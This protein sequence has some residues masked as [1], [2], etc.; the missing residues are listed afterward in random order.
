MTKCKGCGIEIQ[1]SDPK[2]LGY[3]P[4]ADSLYCQRCFRLMHYD[5]LQ[6]S[7]KQGID[8][9]VV[10]AGIAKQEGLI[11]WVCDIF[12]FEA[13]MIEGLNRHL[14]GRDILMVITKRDL[15]PDTLS[16][17]K[18]KR[19]ILER[20]KAYQIN[21]KGIIVTGKGI[22]NK[23]DIFAALELLAYHNI[24]V[25]GKANVGK[26]TLLNQ[27]SANES[28]TTSRYPGTTLDLIDVDIEGYH[29]ID[30]P[31]IEVKKS[32]IMAVEEKD[33]KAVMPMRKIKPTIFQLYEDQAFIIGGLL[34]VKLFG[35]KQ[36][37][38]VFYV[39]NDIK[40]HRTKAQ[41]AD[42]QWNNHLG[43]LY[44][45]VTI[46]QKYTQTTTKKQYD[47]MDI[48][49]DGLGWLCVSGDVQSIEIK[50]P[51]DV[52]IKYRKAAI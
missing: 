20:L 44:V 32:M 37:S 28:L 36:T 17:E 43:K 41:N 34:M 29:F 8:P 14:L 24:I 49:I 9:D 52:N 16:N 25:M 26:S 51:Q 3:S 19:F 50:Y 39:S 38:V 6:Y 46:D 10:L 13:S 23:A 33:L 47:K 22:D 40:I 15:L 48:V 18:L 4:K 42:K 45:P 5:D 12:D 30:T 1:H 35:C 7:M 2:Q 31:G 21:V 11:M 27:L